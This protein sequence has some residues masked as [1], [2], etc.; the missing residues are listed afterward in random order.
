MKG[1]HCLPPLIPHF[2]ANARKAFSNGK[3]RFSLQRRNGIVALL[4]TVIGD[5]G[6]QMVD[7]VITNVAGKPSQDSRQFVKLNMSEFS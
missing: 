3:R 6:A 2:Q 7:M 5:S 4:Q 1:N